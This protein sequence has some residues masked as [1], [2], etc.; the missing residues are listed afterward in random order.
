MEVVVTTQEVVDQDEVFAVVESTL[1]ETPVKTW[2]KD[3]LP[4]A[5]VSLVTQRIGV[6]CDELSFDKSAEAVFVL[7]GLK[8]GFTLTDSDLIP[9]SFCCKNYGSTLGDNKAAVQSQIEEEIREGRYVVCPDSPYLVSSLG[10]ILKPNK[11][12]V[13]L[14]HDF[15]RPDGGVNKLVEDSSVTYSTIDQAV[16]EIVPGSFLAKCDL[17]TAYRSIP[18][19]KSV[20]HLTGLQWTF[21]D[22]LQPTYMYDARLPFGA[23]KSCK[24]FSAISDAITRIMRS[25]GHLVLSYIDDFLCIGKDRL[26][27]QNTLDVLLD[28][29]TRLG[30]AVNPKKTE[31]AAEIMTFLGVSLDC[32]KRTMSL[33]A[34]KLMELKVQLRMWKFKEKCTKKELQSFVG[35][36]NWCAR[37]VRGGQ[38]F[39]RCLINLITKVKSSHHH[40]R[41]TKEAKGDVLWWLEGLNFFHGSTPLICDV[42][43]PAHV[44]STDACETGGGAH[45]GDDWV[46]VAWEKDFPECFGKHINVL[47]LKS[48]VVAAARWGPVWS[49]QHILV[50]SDNMATVAAIN[51]TSSRSVELLELV[52]ELFWL[53]VIYKF[54]ITARY[55]PGIENIMSDRISR[56]SAV[57]SAHEARLLLMGGGPGVIYC[58]GHMSYQAFLYLQMCWRADWNG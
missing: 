39:M 23:A 57:L 34:D 46:Y 33:P 4:D 10:A 18:L 11:V 30:L 45:F 22:D 58:K 25:K 32:I 5:P 27:C 20:Y 41:L 6:W 55:L 52:R 44:F 26:T 53:S 19:H 37:V 50:R 31:N 1:V 2:N 54:K 3:F 17:K 35:R 16:R 49:G 51:K 42:P 36:L 15:S 47:E 38:T 14:I 12:D 40:I 7:D 8:N 48:V 43:L 28:L 9:S 24:I 21:D 56:L 13:R 29:I